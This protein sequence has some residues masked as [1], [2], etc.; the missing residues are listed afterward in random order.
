MVKCI[1]C[2]FKA[3][4]KSKEHIIP[5]WLLELTGDP[6]RIA[7][8]GLNYSNL[9]NKDECIRKFNFS[10]FTFPACSVCNQVYGNDLESSARQIIIKVLN[11]EDLNESELHVLLDWFDK[12]RIGLWIGFN[13]FMKKLAPTEKFYINE[14]KG[15]KDRVLLVYKIDNE[16][17]GLTFSGH[18]PLFSAFPCCFYLRINN[19]V[20]VN[21]SKDNLL[22][23]KLGFPFYYNEIIQKELAIKFNNMSSGHTQIDNSLLNLYSFSCYKKAIFQPIFKLYPVICS[24]DIPYLNNNSINRAAG[25][26]NIFVVHNCAIQNIKNL[27]GLY[28]LNSESISASGLNFS[29]HVLQ[30]LKMFYDE[31]M[32]QSFD[33]QQYKH[34]VEKS[35][36]VPIAF[37]QQLLQLIEQEFNKF[38]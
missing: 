1:F 15:L 30:T 13:I 23:E 28:N 38:E 8:F 24:M 16:L 10:S 4:N 11:D 22:L 12:L 33:S 37:N 6:N 34:E 9:L 20:F 5:R 29:Y 31:L 7:N 35:F 17:M 32:R 21:I 18:S 36:K 27:G 2:G 25:I 14:R 19:Y 3:E 26:G